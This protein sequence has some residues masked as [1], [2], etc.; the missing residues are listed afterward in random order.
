MRTLALR[1]AAATMHLVR[2]YN[3]FKRPVVA[4]TDS[5]TSAAAHFTVV[6]PPTGARQS[7]AVVLA[8]S[9]SAGG[10]RNKAEKELQHLSCKIVSLHNTERNPRVDVYG[11]LALW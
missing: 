8:A 11:G 9:A 3:P 7:T 6:S 2:K 10:K 5:P 1:R 4:G